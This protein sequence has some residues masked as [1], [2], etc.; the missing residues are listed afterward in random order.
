[1]SGN[2]SP[3]LL[4]DYRDGDC[5]SV[6]AMFP[7]G[8]KKKYD[9]D[10][11]STVEDLI[12]AILSDRSVEKP[13]DRTVCLLYHGKILGNNEMLSKIDTIDGFTVSVLFRA[14]NKVQLSQS[15]LQEPRGFDRLQ[16]MN[17]TPQQIA[18][19]RCQF[20]LLRGSASENEEDRI[21]AEDEWFPV[22]FNSENPLESLQATL[23][24][25]QAP[26]PRIEMHQNDQES[27]W[28]TF[29]IAFVLG[30]IFGPASFLFLLVALQDRPGIF[31]I[32]FGIIV[33][34][35]LQKTFNLSLL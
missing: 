16:R 14:T 22:I 23:P 21:E 6:N 9:L 31:G 28:T 24:A 4:E 30:I 12:S 3:L 18:E 8:L 34:Y 10:F 29:I 17:Y 35:F 20:H 2:D 5:L 32:L 19:I 11:G 26:M 15:T 7:S 27:T 33:H 13:P 25:V 1:M